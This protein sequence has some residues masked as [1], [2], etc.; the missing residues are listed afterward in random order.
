MPF[1]GL[2]LFLSSLFRLDEHSHVGLLARV[3]GKGYLSQS[4][5]DYSARQLTQQTDRVQAIRG[6]LNVQGVKYYWATP[7]DQLDAWQANSPQTIPSI[8]PL[9][10]WLCWRSTTTNIVPATS[11]F[12]SWSWIAGE[13]VR[14]DHSSDYSAR[15]S[16]PLGYSCKVTL[17]SA[18]F[19]RTNGLL[20]S[21]SDLVK[22][23]GDHG[24]IP[25][26][27]RCLHLRAPLYHLRVEVSSIYQTN[28][29][30]QYL[31]P[32]L[33]GRVCKM[34]LYPDR[35]KPTI[36]T[37]KWITFATLVMKFWHSEEAVR[38]TAIVLEP[39]GQ[40]YQRFGFLRIKLWPR[41]RDPQGSNSAQVRGKDLED[42][43]A[44]I[45]AVAR[46]MEQDEQTVQ[47][48]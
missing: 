5:E 11:F 24:E 31:C 21:S 15:K 35:G 4:I 38:I 16:R 29:R 1:L 2:D 28:I 36:S 3:L 25:E 37:E 19:Q 40:R 10:H 30:G 32:R 41:E 44:V 43:T 7:L 48:E 33:K 9:A 46:S 42:Q 17:R 8:K 27:G 22:I 23:A 26:A 45:N 34:R 13:S 6:F 39:K 12:P 18:L 14:F 20:S 47:I